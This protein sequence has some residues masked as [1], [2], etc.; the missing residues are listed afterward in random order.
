MRSGA[1]DLSGAAGKFRTADRH[2]A[3]ERRGPSARRRFA[4][5]PYL[6]RFGSLALLLFAV[7]SATT[8][9]PIAIRPTPDLEAFVGMV[10]KEVVA[11]F[12]D[13]GLTAENLSITLV[14]LSP[15]FPS[16]AYRGDASYYPASVVKSFY[17]VYYESQKEAR[18]LA[19][20][21]ELVRAVG[22]MTRL[23][24][25]DATGFVVDSITGT[26]TRWISPLVDPVV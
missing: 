13:K 4:R 26:T 6:K 11:E 22:D 3:R 12:A 21:P 15:T 7:A 17:L 8:A 9:G 18:K 23:S 24:S 19:D 16:G 10:A 5:S 20:T 25:N 1:A 14:E 2:G